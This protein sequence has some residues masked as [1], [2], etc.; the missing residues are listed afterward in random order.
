M[1]CSAASW[2]SSAASPS[3][4]GSF[5]R[6]HGPPPCFE[7]RHAHDARMSEAGALVATLDAHHLVP[8][9][10]CTLWRLRRR[11]GS[12]PPGA[13]VERRLQPHLPDNVPQGR[14][15][16]LRLG[17]RSRGGTARRSHD[18]TR[19]NDADQGR[20][21]RGHSVGE[22]ATILAWRQSIG[23]TPTRCRAPR[24]AQSGRIRRTVRARVGGVARPG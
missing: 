14:H 9:F 8:L 19:H 12:G 20:H 18:A 24:G 1:E 5:G 10:R 22:A 6:W 3:R 15:N 2:R 23:D 11:P 4:S 13:G 17:I 21:A 7:R 16:S